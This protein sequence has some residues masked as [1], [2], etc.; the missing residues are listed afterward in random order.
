MRDFIRSCTEKID[1]LA[2]A[3]VARSDVGLEDEQKIRFYTLVTFVGITMF[4]SFTIVDLRAGAVARA[5][6]NLLAGGGQVLSLLAL[7]RLKNPK[8][9]FRMSCSVAGVFFLL[10]MSGV[11]KRAIGFVWMLFMP[12]YVLFLLGKREG[13]VWTAAGFL[14]SLCILAY[15]TG[16]FSTYSYETDTWARFLA[17]YGLI[18][19]VAY[20]SESTRERY[21]EQLLQFQT[22][23]FQTLCA[24]A[25]FGMVII[26]TDGDFEYVNP[27]FKEIFGYDLSDVP[28]V[29]EL[30]RKAYP[31]RAYRYE[32]ISAWK[33]DLEGLAPGETR[34]RIFT[35]TCKDGS[36]KIIQFRVVKLRTGEYLATCEDI[37]ARKQAEEALRQSQEMLSLA[38]DGANVGIWD[39][40][41]TTGKALWSERNHKM[42]GYEPNEFEPNLK[43]WK[44][45]VHPD[46]WPKVSESLK[47]HMEGNFPMYEAE[48][49]T[50]NKSGDWQWVQ[51]RGKVIEFD[52]YGKPFRMTGV[53]LDVTD[54]KRIEAALEESER[55][56]RTLVETARDIIWT[57][58]LDLKYTYVSPSITEALG[59][60][61][62]EIM[63]TKSVDLLTPA[64]RERVTK[65]YM[66]EME[67]EIPSPRERFV[68]RTEEMEVYHKD[69]S[70]RWKE[71]TTTFLRDH[72]G[73]PN[74]IFGISRDISDRK[75]VE[76]ELRE[77]HANLEKRVEE[78][79]AELSAS[80]QKLRREME[81]RIKAEESL[82]KSEEH[83]RAIVETASDYIFIKDR[84]L[85]Y[86]FVN[87][88]FGNLVGLPRESILGTT[89]EQIFGREAAEH[90]EYVEARVL[91]GETV[92]EEHTKTVQGNP[93]TFLDI[94]APMYDPG[95]D[96]IGICGI[97]RNI[98]E[99][100]GF[101]DF[102]GAGA[103]RYVSEAMRFVLAQST[104]AAQVDSIVLLTGE[105]G[106][107]KDYLAR[108]IHDHSK[109][110]SGSFYSVNCA[111][112]PSGLAESELFGH[113]AG[114]F[115]GSAGRKRGMLELAEG[116]TIL[117]NEIGELPPEL[118]AKL[119]T[120]LDT[121][122]FTR[123]GGEKSIRVNARL[124]AATNKDLMKEVA[125][126]RFRQ[127]L[128]YRLQVF[129]LKVPPLRDRK[130]DIPRLVEELLSKL[131]HQGAWHHQGS[132]DVTAMEKLIN[133][134]W[135]GN[136][137]ELRNVLERALIL[138]KG[139]AIRANHL[140][141]PDVKDDPRALS[142]N[143][144]L[145]ESLDVLLGK[146][147][148]SLIED[149]LRQ[150]QSNQRAAA[151]LLGISRFALAR[152]MKKLGINKSE[153]FETP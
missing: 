28:N 118:Q 76:S 91:T 39:W 147:K 64:S 1:S 73:R 135:P 21:S 129:P 141:L 111:A 24:N 65:A 54:R 60:T 106:A 29:R 103:L 97:S 144:P 134:A 84:S 101:R 17:V 40:D 152:H 99:R 148:R 50:L 140:V 47:L 88:A 43:N 38:L 52:K 61:V 56:F 8:V 83:L 82:R 125:E 121:R 27:M 128:F 94:R 98:T 124:I 69:G 22:Q 137:R 109:R 32:V 142:A 113:E 41:L 55:R 78:R 80:N 149:A 143:F 33:W 102:P 11:G 79:T 86:I 130:E 9:A 30:F 77:A 51:S 146:I 112:I 81:A 85:K 145:T 131:P 114:A 7:R 14:A 107:G 63:G 100:T 105:S 71:V 87:P 26:N 62:A 139:R 53:V 34:S 72:D 127:D 12:A 96:V 59:Y 138:S 93:M 45:L 37:T 23:R 68:S 117:L 57:L 18:S 74:G 58:D 123:V 67:K 150:S 122:S 115:T 49:R 89:D 153:G 92:E 2:S 133:Y 31:D 75:R 19:A 95:G 35:V 15:P 4:I 90:T 13:L 70:T 151:H 104:L 42:L 44:K 25:P 20:F 3:L 119:L 48:Y 46:D 116:G 132:V 108:H 5:V 10:L 136:V 6:L 66:D 36:E 120:F 16:L 110:S 126:G